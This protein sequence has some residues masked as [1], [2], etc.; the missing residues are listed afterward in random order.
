M[1]LALGFGQTD[2]GAALA[3]A[4]GARCAAASAGRALVRRRLGRLPRALK[5]AARRRGVA[6]GDATLRTRR[7][8][9]PPR[10]QDAPRRLVASP[11][12]PWVWGQGLDEARPTPTTS[13]GRATSTRSPPALLAAG[14]RARRDRAVDYLFTVQQ[15]ADGSF[16]QNSTVD[17]TPK[18]DERAA[19][20]DRAAD[21]AR[22]A[23][24]AAPTS[25]PQVKRAADFIVAN[26]PDSRRSA[27]RTRA[28][29]RRRRSPP[30]SPA[31]C[32]RPTS[33]AAR[34]PGERRRWLKTA[35]EWQAKVEGWTATTNGPYD[36]KPYYLRAHQGRPPELGTTYDLGDS[37]PA[38]VDQR[39][40]VDPSFLELVRLGVKRADD[41][42][43]R[44]TRRGRSTTQLGV[45]RP[46]APS[47]TATRA[48]ATASRPTAPTGTSTSRRAPRRAAGSGRSSPASAASTS[49]SPAGRARSR[50]AAMAGAANDG[51][52]IPEQVWDENPPSG[53]PGSRRRGDAL[54]HAAGVVARAVPAARVVARAGR[55]APD[56]SRPYERGLRA[57]AGASPPARL[58]PLNPGEPSA[59][60]AQRPGV[61][62][63][64]RSTALPASPGPS[65]THGRPVEARLGQERGDPVR[66]DLALAEVDVAVAVGAERGHESLTCRE[67]SRSRPTIRSNSSTTP[68]SPSAV[69]MS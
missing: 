55:R 38:D 30:R 8:C 60:L 48:T 32:A 23:A 64:S 62:M 15:E 54:G 49:C 52:M 59:P 26:G 21:R 66:A 46:T 41:P 10:G 33:P 39:E 5:R 14:D 65:N 61:S 57:D 17:G 36:P 50:L 35:D 19:R 56:R 1:T 4:A 44:N 3:A 13:C 43:I 34:R 37:G 45:R 69:R 25:Y 40:V 63:S 9:S 67:P 53:Q 18:W 42:V 51:L 58:T 16:P 24:R 6:A 7:W 29:T 27:G 28:A 31:W 2:A 22:L 47:G 68:E 12:M 11:S 20:R